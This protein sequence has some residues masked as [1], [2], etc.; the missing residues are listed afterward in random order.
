MVTLRS[1]QNSKAIRA[2]AVAR[3]AK[4]KTVQLR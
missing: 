2:E 1:F 4:D 3:N